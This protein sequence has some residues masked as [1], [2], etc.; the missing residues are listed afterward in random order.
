MPLA[1]GNS[2]LLLV[3]S[4]QRYLP[5]GAAMMLSLVDRECAAEEK[6]PRA[7]WEQRY[8]GK[9]SILDLE[10][11]AL[12]E[13]QH[14]VQAG[15]QRNP[16]RK[17]LLQDALVEAR[18]ET[19][20]QALV[21]WLLAKDHVR[22]LQRLTIHPA[23]WMFKS[24]TSERA[25]VT[26]I[27]VHWSWRTALELGAEWHD[28]IFWI[29]RSCLMQHQLID[30]IPLEERLCFFERC[31]LPVVGRVIS[32]QCLLFELCTHLELDMLLC[33][34]HQHLLA[35]APTAQVWRCVD[36]VLM[37]IECN[38]RVLSA[39]LHSL[40][41]WREAV[42]LHSLQLW[43]YESNTGTPFPSRYPQ[44]IVEAMRSGNSETR[45]T[46]LDFWTL[47]ASVQQ[48]VALMLDEWH[49][50]EKEHQLLLL[51]TRPLNQ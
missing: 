28:R 41:S 6:L 39:V 10:L 26:E 17:Q 3:Q 12:I 34:L 27:C 36:I 21:R 22:A 35:L 51:L 50:A 24:V 30:G 4:I 48:E 32:V 33:V 19:D 5:V 44:P 46:I 11:W 47:N 15:Q 31:V 7:L 49:C 20:K 13:G 1:S 23:E 18:L 25:G 45:A 9:R 37:L 38:P 43:I 42:V 16:A 8:N 2:A 29:W 40:Q 14:F